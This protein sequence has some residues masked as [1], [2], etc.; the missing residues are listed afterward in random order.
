M[1]VVLRSFLLATF[2]LIFTCATPLVSAA[3]TPLVNLDVQQA[4]IRDVL[5]ALSKL[6][7]VSII[8]DDSVTGKVTVQLSNI[9]FETAL[10]LITRTKGLSY[11]RFNDIIVVASAEKIS[12]QYSQLQV[13]PLQ[14]AKAEELQKSLQGIV[15][16]K[17]L[18][19]DLTTNALIFNG[20][21]GEEEKLRESIARLDIPYKQITLE[22]QIVSIVQED[23]KNLGLSWEWD[24]VPS[25]ASTTS[26]SSSDTTSSVKA[27]KINFGPGY[28]FRYQATLSAMISNGRAKILASPRITTTPGKEAM[29][30]IGDHIPVITEKVSDNTTTQTTEYVDAGIK[31]IYTPQVNDEGYITAKVHTEVS[32]PTL[33][34]ELKNYRITTR[35]A[36]T[37][38]RMKEG[39]TLVIGGLI[40]SEESNSLIKV[41]FLSNLPILGGLFKDV[42]KSKVST[43]VIIFLKPTI[44]YPEQPTERKDK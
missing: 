17:Y 26:S 1:F 19:S 11:R 27:G 44:L 18:K 14:Y 23:K 2:L 16:S 13:F 35:S 9:P 43:E 39:E 5:T 4:E 33:V 36:D 7:R 38:V 15:D 10:D 31:L 29:I 40:N 12:Q 8:A 20:P 37:Y 30:F 28:V 6:A 25:S 34:S 22:A 41:P 24:E 32:T 42:S 3:T 21:R